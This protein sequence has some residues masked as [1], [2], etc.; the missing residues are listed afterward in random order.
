M[1]K[2]L[3]NVTET[4]QGLT[5][6]QKIL[7]LIILSVVI[8]S[9]S[10]SVSY[11]LFSKV[12]VSPEKEKSL[13]TSLPGPSNIVEEDASEPK[14][15]TCPLNGSLKSK[16]AKDSWEKRRPL[17]VMVE[18]HTE[19]RPQSGLSAADIIYEAVAEGGITRF[20]AIYYCNLSDVQVGP[21]RSARTYYLDWLEEYSALYAHVGGANTPGP[22]DALGQIIKYKIHDLN[23][24][25]IGFPVFWRDYQRLGRAVATEHT[26]YSTTQKLWEVGAKRG[27]TATDSAGIRWDKNF[28]PWKFKE[29]KSPTGSSAKAGVATSK[30]T[31]N[32]WQNQPQY[33][34]EWNYD[35]SSNLYKRKNGD[36]HMDLNNKQQL[37]AKNIIVQFQRESN[38]ND[39]YPGNV[40]L[41]YQT[42]GSGKALIFQDGQ[43]IEGKWVKSSRVSRTKFVDKN[44]REIE[45]NKGQIWIQTVP[46]GSKVTY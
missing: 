17:A 9:A 6:L 32:F 22:A 36:D 11:S 28:A 19:A 39:G 5:N 15:E 45:L 46:E 23:Q 40:H 37:A 26:M 1:N 27:W 41:L 43:V 35:A 14:T 30:I 13:T 33:S 16:R 4:F 21:V 7:V 25:S 29:E 24:F 18:N 31:V 34:V 2:I 8:Y 42:S 12:A 3:N 38:A 20:M 44:N 10:A